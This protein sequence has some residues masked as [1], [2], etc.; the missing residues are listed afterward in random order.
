MK[1][2]YLFTSRSPFFFQG[3][4]NCLVKKGRNAKRL[5]VLKNI[6]DCNNTS[7]LQV[8]GVGAVG[9]Q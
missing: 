2:S 6:N 1:N 7:I 3:F 8:I 9:L 4:H 5:W